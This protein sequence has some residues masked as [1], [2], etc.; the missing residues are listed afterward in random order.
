MKAAATPSQK[1]KMPGPLCPAPKAASMMMSLEKKPA[2]PRRA[3]HA[4]AGERQAADP[5]QRVG[6]GDVRFQ[7]P[8]ILRMSCSSDMAW[9]TEPAPRNS[10]ALKKAWVIRW[11]IARRRPIRRRRRTCSRAGCRS[12]RR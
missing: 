5:H 1:A 7:M 6:H 10:S 11:K 4:D 12:N 3:R 8:P 9:I 2:K